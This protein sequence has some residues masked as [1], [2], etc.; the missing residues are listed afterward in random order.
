MWK[1]NDFIEIF[2]QN[3][4]LIKQTNILFRETFEATSQYLKKQIL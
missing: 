2:I 4:L 3:W 1:N